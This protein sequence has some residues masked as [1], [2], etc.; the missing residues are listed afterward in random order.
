MWLK[1]FILVLIL[2]FIIGAIIYE[3]FNSMVP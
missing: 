1:N 2:S 3:L